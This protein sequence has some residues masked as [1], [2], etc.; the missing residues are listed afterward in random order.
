MWGGGNNFGGG[1]EE[2]ITD[3]FIQTH[4][5]GGLNSKSLLTY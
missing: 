3:N 4:I 1:A 2:R 5:P